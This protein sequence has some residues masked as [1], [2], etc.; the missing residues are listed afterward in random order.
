MS[1]REEQ[2]RAAWIR[3]GSCGSTGGAG[4]D[5]GGAGRRSKVERRVWTPGSRI[6]ARPVSPHGSDYG[7]PFQ[8][9]ISVIDDGSI[10]PLRLFIRNFHGAIRRDEDVRWLQIAMDDAALMR[11]VERIGDLLDSSTP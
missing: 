7:L 4:S 1:Q 5:V 8:L 11:R 6:G 10:A 9:K 2:R 3:T